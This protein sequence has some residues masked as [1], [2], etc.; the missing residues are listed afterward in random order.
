MLAAVAS[1]FAT[2]SVSLQAVRQESLGERARLGVVTHL[3]RQEQVVAAVA[4]LD[5]MPE[6]TP[7]ISL[8]RV[9]GA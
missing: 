7:G 4:E 6:V 8:M 1:A 9:E 3:A 2:Q 5:R